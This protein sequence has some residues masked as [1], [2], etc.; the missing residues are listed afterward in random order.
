[1]AFEGEEWEEEEK[2]QWLDLKTE[3]DDNHFHGDQVREVVGSARNNTTIEDMILQ[4]RLAAP[5]QEK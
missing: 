5:Y 3:I 4:E 1:M 2:G